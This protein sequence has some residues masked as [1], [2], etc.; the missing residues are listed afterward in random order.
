M[1]LQHYYYITT[2]TP[3]VTAVPPN[4]IELTDLV[5]YQGFFFTTCQVKYPLA[6]AWSDQFVCEL[7]GS[8]S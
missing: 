5:L 1:T 3:F 8:D 7:T 4:L 6:G 2:L